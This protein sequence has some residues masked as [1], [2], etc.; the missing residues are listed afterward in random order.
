MTPADLL[1]IA[2]FNASKHGI[3][4]K[5]GR[6]NSAVGDCLLEA[7]VFN[8]NDRACFPVKLSE[9]MF[10]EFRVQ[11]CTAAMKNTIFKAKWKD[12]SQDK[13]EA[14]WRAMMRQYE[15]NV[16]LMADLMPHAVAIGMQNILLIFNTSTEVSHTPI[17]VID[18]GQYG[19]QPSTDIPILLCWSGNH[20]ESLEPCDEEAQLGTIVLAKQF[21]EGKYEFTKHDLNQFLPPRKTTW[22]SVVSTTAATPTIPTTSSRPVRRVTSPAATY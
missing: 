15:Y 19:V 12:S 2:I 4:L 5:P 11:W 9:N 21:I 17:T 6:K 3:E 22:A 14:G 1:R 16:D 20:Y 13:W 8:R 10:S 7:A 18:P